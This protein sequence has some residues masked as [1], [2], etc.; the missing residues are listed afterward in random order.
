M[1]DYRAILTVCEAIIRQFRVSY[2]PELF[3]LPR[4]EFKVCLSPELL[5]RSRTLRAGVTLFLYE[6]RHNPA[7][8]NAPQRRTDDGRLEPLAL[9]L[10]IRFLLTAWAREAST[11]Q[12]ISGWMMRVMEDHPILLAAALNN[13]TPGAFH[14][15]E[16]VEIVLDEL[17]SL[18]VLQ[19][20]EKSVRSSYQLSIPYL[21]RNIAVETLQP[22]QKPH[23][24]G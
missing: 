15:D 10:D 4:L 12:A 6:V 5:S 17:S 11:Q 21:A 13:V 7:A 24:S 20:W 1:A 14:P 8:R 23:D 9:Q 19:I 2:M 3:N 18:D 22:A 16:T